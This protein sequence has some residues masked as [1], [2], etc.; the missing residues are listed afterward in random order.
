MPILPSIEHRL[1][2]VEPHLIGDEGIVHR[3]ELEDRAYFVK[4]WYAAHPQTHGSEP[5]Y[6]PATTFLT[7]QGIDLEQLKPK[8]DTTQTFSP[9]WAKLI[10]AE[11]GV[12]HTLFPEHTVAIEAAY[13]P[14]IDA[15]QDHT[16]DPRRGL[17]V[18]VSRAV[19]ADPNKMPAIEAILEKV[20]NHIAEH[21]TT[22]SVFD[23]TIDRT[24][25]NALAKEIET[26]TGEHLHLESSDKKLTKKMDWLDLIIDYVKKVAPDSV[27]IDMLRAGILPMHPEINFIPTAEQKSKPPHGVII[28]A[29]IVNSQRLKKAIHKRPLDQ[30]P[31][32]LSDIGRFEKLRRADML[33]DRWYGNIQDRLRMHR[34]HWCDDPAVAS[35]L[36]EL[37]Q[38]YVKPDTQYHTPAS[39]M[40]MLY[41]DFAEFT[42]ADWQN[43]DKIVDA[44]EML[45]MD[46]R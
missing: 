27:L 44:I 23:S 35:V 45:K 38:V 37:V 1:R 19:E 26:I 20:Y 39:V 13:D 8:P 5:Y 2:G 11:Q 34:S 33:F 22:T 32:L 14:R 42:P 4:H 6:L 15:T 29:H 28:E 24:V 31:G 9:F 43:R 46:V 25:L 16:F 7:Q 18:T 36:F 3:V 40:G 12:I 30:R 21:T 17:P 41:R 10:H